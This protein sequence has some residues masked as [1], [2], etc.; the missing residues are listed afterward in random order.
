MRTS[1]NPAAGLP[2]RR[3]KV[4]N[5]CNA[6]KRANRKRPTPAFSRTR[7]DRQ[8]R[9]RRPSASWTRAI[10]RRATNAPNHPGPLL[11]R[12]ATLSFGSDSKWSCQVEL[13]SSVYFYRHKRCL[14]L[15]NEPVPVLLG[16]QRQNLMKTIFHAL[17]AILVVSC[18]TGCASSL[19]IVVAGDGRADRNFRPEDKNGLNDTINREMARA[20]LREKAKGAFSGQGTWST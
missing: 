17:A 13:P 10:P 7:G 16:W 2:A 8:P 1:G 18:L 3:G 9:L 14:R 5:R 20:V 15:Y 12:S 4:E 6:G 19:R 11:G